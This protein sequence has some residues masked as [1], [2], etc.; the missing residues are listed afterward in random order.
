M[1]DAGDLLAQITSVL[2]ASINPNLTTR[3]SLSDLYEA[4]LF[5][6]IVRAAREEQAT[7]QYRSVT[8]ATVTDL[9]FRRSPGFLNST[10]HPYTHARIDVGSNRGRLEAHVGVRTA[11]KSG[12]LHECDVLILT[13]AEAERC[14]RQ[15][16]APR[17]H[18]LL[19]AVEAKFYSTPLP[20]AEARGFVG[21]RADF[22]ARDSALIAN[23]PAAEASRFLSARTEYHETDLVPGSRAVDRFVGR[24][25]MVLEDHRRR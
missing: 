8:G 15:A 18:A 1:A 2:G 9:V 14:R 3:D 23:V 17:S 20:L 19:L 21:L 5:S 11:G 12:V 10:R 6:L 24:V 4:Y 13:E 25:R 16:L 22:S 7:V